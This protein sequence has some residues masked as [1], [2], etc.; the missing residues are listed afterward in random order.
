LNRKKL[1]WNGTGQRNKFSLLHTEWQGPKILILPMPA[2][3]PK[4]SK[5]FF[6]VNVHLINFIYLNPNSVNHQSTT[7]KS[8]KSFST[9]S[10]GQ[11]D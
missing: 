4:T 10:D 7:V 3:K 5:L 1:N 8:A 11:L 6:A 2:V 9:L